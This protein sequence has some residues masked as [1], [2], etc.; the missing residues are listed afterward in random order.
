MGPQLLALL[1]LIPSI[2]IKALLPLVQRLL[3]AQTMEWAIL[4]AADQLVKRTETPH[5]DEFLAEV[6]TLLGKDPK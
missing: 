4:W 1:Q 2:A 5:D 3:T 6:K